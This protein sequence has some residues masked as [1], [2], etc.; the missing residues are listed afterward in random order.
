MADDPTPFP[1]HG[2]EK[3]F[4]S[5][6]DEGRLIVNGWT[7]PMARLLDEDGE[8]LTILL[9]NRM[10]FQFPNDR[11]AGTICSMVAHA[12]ALGLGLSHAPGPRD[13]VGPGQEETTDSKRFTQE[14]FRL[15]ASLRPSMVFGIGAIHHAEPG[16]KPV[17]GK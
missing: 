13:G 10:G 2:P 15:H 5:I 9:D 7:V 6:G 4:S 14:L 11:N 8:Y 12:I 1:G 17:G 3:N 16:L